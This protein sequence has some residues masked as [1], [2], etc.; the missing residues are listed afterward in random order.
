[1]LADSPFKSTVAAMID[2]ARTQGL[3]L[4]LGGGLQ[5]D[6]PLDHFKRGFSNDAAPFYTHELVCDP[7][8]YE[9]LSGGRDAGGF[10]PAYRA[11]AK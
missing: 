5:P 1:M 10:F 11:P 3:P 6:D 8:V 9:R 4:N 2:L 7:G